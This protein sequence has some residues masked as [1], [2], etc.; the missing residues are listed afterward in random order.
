MKVFLYKAARSH[1]AQPVRSKRLLNLLD[2]LQELQCLLLS[3][4][5]SLLFSKNAC[6]FPSLA[7]SSAEVSPPPPPWLYID[8]R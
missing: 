3:V 6:K 2:V 4:S 1:N 7:M 5:L 8:Q